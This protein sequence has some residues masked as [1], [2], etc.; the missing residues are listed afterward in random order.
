MVELLHSEHYSVHSTQFSVGQKFALNSP[1]PVNS[2]RRRV[3]FQFALLLAMFVKPLRS[4][5]EGNESSRAIYR[6]VVFRNIACT[7]GIGVAYAVTTVVV[8]VAI[9][10]TSPKDYNMVRGAFPAKYF[11]GT[12]W[13]KTNNQNRAKTNRLVDYSPIRVHIAHRTGL[14]A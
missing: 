14:I 7:I 8:A 6:K 3:V 1:V 2:P 4:L 9:F 5:Q 12:M 13:K 11:Q 10:N